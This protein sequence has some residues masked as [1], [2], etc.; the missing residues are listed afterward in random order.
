MNT[1]TKFIYLYRTNSFKDWFTKVFFKLLEFCPEL[2]LLLKWRK[3]NLWGK[4]LNKMAMNCSEK[5][6]F[7]T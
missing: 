5:L 2:K 3:S 6:S 7:I 4:T 1:Y